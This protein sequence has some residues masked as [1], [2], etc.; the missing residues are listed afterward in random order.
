MTARPSIV[1]RAAC[2][3]SS[4]RSRRYSP[5]D[6]SALSSSPRNE[7]GSLRILLLSTFNF[8]LQPKQLISVELTDQPRTFLDQPR[9]DPLT[10]IVLIVRAVHDGV[11][12]A[13]T[14]Q[15]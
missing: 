7:R 9:T 1:V 12:G 4:T 3:S 10:F 14:H 8:L 15:C 6:F 5:W 11:R 13:R 2:R